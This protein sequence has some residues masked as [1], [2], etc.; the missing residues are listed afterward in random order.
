MVDPDRF[1]SS[2]QRV[3]VGMIGGEAGCHVGTLGNGAVAGDQHV[4]VPGGLTQPIECRLVGA[5]LI[6]AARVQKRDQDVGEHVA[7]DRT[8]RSARRT[9]AWPMAWGLVA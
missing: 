3:D 5:H 8:P 7:G 6:R 1:L 9:A 4:D 2:P